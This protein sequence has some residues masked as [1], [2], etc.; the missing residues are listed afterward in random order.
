MGQDQRDRAANEIK[1]AMADQAVSATEL[2]R[3]AQVSQNTITRVTRGEN[4]QDGTLLKVR[5]A[6]G[7]RPVT[8]V[9]TVDPD[10]EA[11]VLAIRTWLN[12]VARGERPHA[13]ADL[14]ECVIDGRVRRALHPNG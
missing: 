1:K 12:G 5:N 13:V 14:I 2:A 10:V 3:R 11:V 8:Q 9:E 4:V 7:I 6:L